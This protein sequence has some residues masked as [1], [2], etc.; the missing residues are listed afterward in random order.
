MVRRVLQDVAH[1][2]QA[3]DGVNGAVLQVVSSNDL[4]CCLH[5]SGVPAAQPAL[6]RPNIN[7][8]IISLV[9]LQNLL[10]W[11]LKPNYSSHTISQNIGVLNISNE[12]TIL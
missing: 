12:D 7:L 2:S 5:H 8:L 6:S 10:T 3:E 9:Q 4:T 11:I 1:P